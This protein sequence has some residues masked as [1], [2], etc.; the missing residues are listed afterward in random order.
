[1]TVCLWL[2]E[3][4]VFAPGATNISSANVAEAWLADS[5]SAVTF[6]MTGS[7]QGAYNG[8]AAINTYWADTTNMDNL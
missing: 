3:T 7:N 4:E 8:Y 2:H 5:E 6:A 1:M